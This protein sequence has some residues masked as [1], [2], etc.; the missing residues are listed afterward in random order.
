M[1]SREEMLRRFAEILAS[2]NTITITTKNK[3]GMV[4]SAKTYYGDEDGYIYVA[5]EDQGHTLSNIKENPEV[6]FVIEKGFAR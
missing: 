5:L 1:L 2:N 3:D 4:W 6:Y